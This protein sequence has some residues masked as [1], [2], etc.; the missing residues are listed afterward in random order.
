LTNCKTFTLGT[1]TRSTE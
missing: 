1:I